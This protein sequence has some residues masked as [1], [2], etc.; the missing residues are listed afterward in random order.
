MKYSDDTRDFVLLSNIVE[1]VIEEVRYFST[2]NFIGDRIDGYEEPVI[3]TTRK[4]AYELKNAS[5]EFVQRGYRLKVY[6]A[7]RPFQAVSHFVRWTENTDD[8]RMKEY[9]YPNL[10]KAVLLKEGY[11]SDH[12]AH[13]RG[14]AI[15]LTLFDM[16]K[17]KEVDMGGLFDLFEQSSHSDYK[18]ITD[19]QYANRMLL[20]EVMCEN[21]FE[22]IKEEW[23]HFILKDEPYP[24]TYFTFPVNSKFFEG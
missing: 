6:D 18:D 9:F 5:K 22:G 8:I 3:I 23:W 24:D 7:Y 16:K 14:S 11:I 21:G 12:S 19:E 10:D 2:F 4:L 20:K 1:D 13:S 17:G 15:D